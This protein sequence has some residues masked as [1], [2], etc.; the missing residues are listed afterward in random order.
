MKTNDLQDN[1][2]TT[3]GGENDTTINSLYL[4]LPVLIPNTETQVIINESIKDICTIT[5]DSWYTECKLSTDG[6]KLQVDIGSTQNVISPK[7]LIAAFRTLDRV[8]AHNK[9]NNIALFDHVIVEKYFA[10]I[11]GYRYP[12]DA[13]LKNFPENDYIDQYR[14]L[15]LFYK[16]Y[17]GEELMNPFISYIDMKNKYPIQVIDL[18]HQVDHITGTQIQLFEEYNTDSVMLMLDYLLY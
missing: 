5:K 1:L 10:E 8:G 2:F 17:V 15:K 14:D 18:G 6:H 11:D 13:D 12:K 4:F 16:E 9:A 3:I 7:Y